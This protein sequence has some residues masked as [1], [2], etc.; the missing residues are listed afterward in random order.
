MSFGSRFL[1]CM[2]PSSA[3]C[4]PAMITRPRTRSAFA[5]IEPRIVVCATTSSP[6]R[7]EK[8]TMK[9]SG[10]L[11]SVDWRTPVRAGPVR[12]PTASVENE[13]TQAR[14]ASAMAPTTKVA[15][16]SASA[17]CSTPVSVESATTAATTAISSFVSPPIAPDS[18]GWAGP[19]NKGPRKA[20]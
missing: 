17:K 16:S 3:R 7:I 5:K 12:A 13:T 14:P 20:P 10:R 18:R 1:K 2:T 9:S 8:R 11:P 6:A 15:T 4:E 19:Q